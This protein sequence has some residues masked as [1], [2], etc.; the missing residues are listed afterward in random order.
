MLLQSFPWRDRL[1]IGDFHCAEATEQIADAKH[2]EGEHPED[3][4]PRF[5]IELQGEKRPNPLETH[6]FNLQ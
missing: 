5:L 1:T 6:R 3:S 2:P 4:V